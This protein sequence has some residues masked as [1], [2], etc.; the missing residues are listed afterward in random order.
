MDGQMGSYEPLQVNETELYDLEKD[1]GESINVATDF[2]EI[3]STID[4]LADEMCMDLGDSLQVIEGS[5]RRPA[6]SVNQT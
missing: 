6:G 1:P 4:A 5:G 2:S 3:I